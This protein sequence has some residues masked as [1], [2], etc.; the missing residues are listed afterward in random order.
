M[1]FIAAEFGVNFRDFREVKRMIGLAKDA[2]VDGVKFQVFREEHIKGHPREAEL[3][4]LIL[5]QSD[6]QFLKDT[7]DEC[8]IEFFAT[9]MY[10]EA[11][12]MLEA[13]GVKRY[14]IRYADR[15]NNDII[16]AVIKTNKLVFLSCDKSYLDHI[17]YQK[18]SKALFNP[19]RIVYIYC[20]PKYPPSLEEIAFPTDFRDSLLN[21]YSNHY[22][23]ISAP[24]AAA[25]R[26][27]EYVEV[28]V[29]NE[30]NRSQYIDNP[31]SITFAE[32]KLLCSLIRDIE[33]MG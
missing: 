8:G 17:M 33:K 15:C 4:E 27:A 22:P 1:V 29:V 9:P 32:L 26:G 2:G 3:H 28:H 11:V 23:S 16:N 25:A 31:V 5:K 6:I 20:T 13:V 21:G 12:D 18:D 14:K 7:A 10:P 24:L 19:A 30:K